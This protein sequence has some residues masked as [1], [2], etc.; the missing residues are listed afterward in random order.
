M[1]I[2][3]QQSAQHVTAPIQVAV[4]LWH[5]VAKLG[6]RAPVSL[7]N[8]LCY[9]QSR[10]MLVAMVTRLSLLSD[11]QAAHRAVASSHNCIAQ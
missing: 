1:I 4:I 3:L 7:F 8:K 10:G 6:E 11:R 2:R 5:S 9:I